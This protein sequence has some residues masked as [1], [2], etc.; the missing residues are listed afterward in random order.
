MF[1]LVSLLNPLSWL[2]RRRQ[3]ERDQLF[4]ELCAMAKTH[5]H[6]I[7]IS[8]A[9]GIPKGPG[10]TSEQRVAKMKA[11]YNGLPLWFIRDVKQRVLDGTL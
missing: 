8:A 4:L 7:D 11:Y 1:S 2:E 10:L 6:A 9:L 3:R 5:D